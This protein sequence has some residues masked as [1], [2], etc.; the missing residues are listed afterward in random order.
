MKLKING[1]ENEIEFNEGEVN[2]LEIENAKCF[3][4]IIEVLNAKINGVESNEMFLLDEEGNL[5]TI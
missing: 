5:S 4:H 3:S 2:V 1:F